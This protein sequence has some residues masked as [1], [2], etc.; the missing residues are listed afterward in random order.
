MG[1]RD[2]LWDGDFKG[3]VEREIVWSTG[4]IFNAAHNVSNAH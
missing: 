4:Q 3:L 2:E 1:E